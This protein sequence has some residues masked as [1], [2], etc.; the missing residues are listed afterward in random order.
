MWTP[1]LTASELRAKP[2]E[3]SSASNFLG[4]N[5]EKCS[6]QPSSHLRSST[7]AMERVL[8]LADASDELL[9]PVVC[10]LGWLPFYRVD[11]VLR[12][13][14]TDDSP[15]VRRIGIAAAAAHRRD[16]GPALEQA[17]SHTDEKLRAR[18]L[19]A[20]GELGRMDLA[21][22]A[23]EHVGEQVADCR[24]AAS[25][26]CALLK[27]DADAIELLRAGAELSAAWP[28]RALQLAVRCGELADT[29]QWVFRLAADP[30]MVRSAITAAAALGNTCH[31]P[32][33]IEMMQTPWT[34]LAGEAFATIVGIDLAREHFDQARPE[35]FDSGPTDDPA[36]EN[37]DMDPDENL[38]WPDQDKIAAWWKKHA[39]DFSS[40]TRYLLGKP[41]TEDWLEHVLRH[42]YQR[43]RAAAALELAIRRP[44]TPLFEVRALASANRSYWA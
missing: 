28:G 36:D 30:A 15:K 7:R 26:S 32:W 21:K 40:G 5:R 44:G 17:L 24:L 19:R 37:V 20:V 6:Q 34:R 23:R 2:A 43:Q 9:R 38:P 4:K 14:L 41:I 12:R 1:T 25:W 27:S 11:G 22:T 8:S 29:D 13:L 3:R 42:G 10:A 33:L 35:G 16:S 18:A 39:T 31:V